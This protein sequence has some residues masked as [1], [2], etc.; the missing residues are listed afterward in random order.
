MC[1]GD[2][3]GGGGGGGWQICVREGEVETG[4]GAP[5]SRQIA[6]SFCALAPDCIGYAKR[7]RSIAPPEWLSRKG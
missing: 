3:S 2:G 1:G 5:P 4:V 6:G 7:A